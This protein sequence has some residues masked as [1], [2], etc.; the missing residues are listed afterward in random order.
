MSHT[1]AADCHPSCVRCF[2]QGGTLEVGERPFGGDRM[3][4]IWPSASVSSSILTWVSL[5]DVDRVEGAVDVSE[6]AVIGVA[7]D[8]SGSER[9]ADSM[10]A[11]GGA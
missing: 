9:T 7:K 8:S 5:V 3:A 4:R 2:F 6:W 1:R 10:G 11:V